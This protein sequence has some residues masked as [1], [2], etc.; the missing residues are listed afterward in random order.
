MRELFLENFC[1]DADK[2]YKERLKSRD[3]EF[4]KC[5]DNASKI[6]DEFWATLTK[7]QQKK[8]R[9]FE[10]EYGTE[11]VIINEDLYAYALKK[12]MAIGFDIGRSFK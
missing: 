1:E 10:F 11:Q 9:E 8:Y 3:K 6:F 12:G 2:V 7:E 4:S 5:R